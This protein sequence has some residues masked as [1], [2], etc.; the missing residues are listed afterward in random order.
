MKQ[1]DMAA[2]SLT[3]VGGLNALAIAADKFDLIG[4]ATGKK[5][6]FGRANIGTRVVYGIIGA[7]AL[8]SL[9]RM[10]EHEAF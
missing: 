3:I 7:G 2:R 9:S 5:G 1:L 4:A 6:R 10:I 8:W